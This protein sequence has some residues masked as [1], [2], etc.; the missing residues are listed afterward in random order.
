[1][2]NKRIGR[3]PVQLLVT[4]RPEM[5]SYA[6]FVNGFISKT[7]LIYYKHISNIG[8]TGDIP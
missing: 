1:M 2:N 5:V 3:K 7:F 4:A 6:L 8:I